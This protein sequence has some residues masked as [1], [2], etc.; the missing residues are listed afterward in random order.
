MVCQSNQKCN[1]ILYRK[2]FFGAAAP[3]SIVQD[4][5]GNPVMTDK[6]MTVFIVDDDKSI[7]RSMR[8]LMRSAGYRNIETFASAEDFLNDAH[9][10]PHSILILDLLLSGMGGIELFRR[11][12]EKGLAIDTVFISARE[13]ELEKARTECPEAIAFLQKPFDMENLLTAVHSIS[14]ADT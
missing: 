4:I 12:R 3:H 7:L 5:R 14:G 13:Q 6:E 2:E 1:W 10:V 8:R 9:I 11:L